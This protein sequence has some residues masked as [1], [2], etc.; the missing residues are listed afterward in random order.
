MMSGD[1][2]YKVT[3]YTRGGSVLVGIK[4]SFYRE[5]KIRLSSPRVLIENI[6]NPLLVLVIFG[7]IFSR[8]IGEIEINE[9]VSINYLTY[10]VIGAINISLVSN[11]LVAATKVFVDKYMGL[12]EEMLSYPVK[13]EEI[14]LGKYIFN[15]ILSI[16]QIVVMLLFVIIIDGIPN[17]NLVSVILFLVLEVIASTF[18][19]FF[20]TYLAVILKNQ[21]GFNTMYFLVMTPVI[22]TSTIYYPI[23]NMPFLMKII[24]VINP[25]TW[26]T[27]L[28]RYYYLGIETDFILI[29]YLL[30]IF[31]SIITYHLSI[32]KYKGGLE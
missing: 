1:V 6:V 20:F 21:D 9:R 5:M 27:D 14:I 12:Y 29:K 11:A 31:I 3:A 2:L 23:D 8:T 24:S 10:F 30:V 4:A 28:G 7:L 17:V 19:F 32:K 16:L 15:L 25:L 13:R 26:L 22:Y 18:L